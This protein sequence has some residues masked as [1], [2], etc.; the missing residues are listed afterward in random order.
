MNSSKIENIK[1]TRKFLRMQAIK[2]ILDQFDGEIMKLPED[3]RQS[4]YKKMAESVFLFYR[5]SAYLF[6]SDIYKTPFPFHTPQDRPTWIQGDLHFENFG[7]FKNGEGE[8]VYDINDFDEGYIGSYLYDVLR[9]T[10]SIVLVAQI[11]GYSIDEQREA[12]GQYLK[13]YYKQIK[14]FAKEKED[15]LECSFTEDNTDGA[16]KKLLK[17]LRKK[18][19]V[20]FLKS[21]TTENE[22][23][24]R[25]HCTSEIEPVTQ[26]E[27]NK[28]LE[29][30]HDYLN[31]L[32]TEDRLADEMYSIKDVAV[33]H[34]SGTASIGLDRYYVLIDWDCMQF[35]V[36]DKYDVVLE[37]KEVRAPVPS[38]FLPHNEEFWKEFNHQ[39][40]RVIT[41]QKAMH[42][43]ADSFLGYL[44][45]DD[46]EFYVRERSPYKK[47][48]KL[49]KIGYYSE[50]LSVI[51][52][53]AK[54]TAKAHSRADAD[55][56]H[57]ILNY[58]SEVEILKA[59]GDDV[60]S[61]CDQITFW[62]LAYTQQVHEDYEIF[63]EW[64]N[65]R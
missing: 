19:E 58:H 50:F 26:E 43:S 37:I 61:F 18:E 11:Q 64:I 42:H 59:M 47:R 39:G 38:Y 63:C 1:N 10:V 23:N 31:S 32:D 17:K 21:I 53:M 33:K 51:D 35:D 4:K 12:A 28:L 45:I 62:T 6:Y 40:K 48:L 29:V 56:K 55:I 14:K 9:M 20:E 30:W 3:K 54:V 7:A 5:G 8:L 41:T 52:I 65:Q 49:E 24:R 13:S 22:I 36:N 44:T 15:S 2:T 27:K 34:G 16:V 57:H 60:D 25:F 46:K